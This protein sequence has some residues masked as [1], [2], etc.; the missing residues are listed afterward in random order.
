MEVSY[1]PDLD[2]RGEGPRGSRRGQYVNPISLATDFA[3]VEMEFVLSGNQGY[4]VTRT[5]TTSRCP[6]VERGV[7]GGDEKSMSDVEDATS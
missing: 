6:R 2:S 3:R 5:S 7:V 4:R 1:G